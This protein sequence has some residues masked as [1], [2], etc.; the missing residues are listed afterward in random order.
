MWLQV[1][2]CRC[3]FV[4]VAAA[5]YVWLWLCVWVCPFTWW[6][7]LQHQ[8]L[9][10]GPL[11]ID[12]HQYSNKMAVIKWV[13]ETQ[14]K[15]PSKYIPFYAKTGSNASKWQEFLDQAQLWLWSGS[16]WSSISVGEVREVNN[17][18]Y[19]LHIFPG[20]SHPGWVTKEVYDRHSHEL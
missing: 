20:C 18:K 3:G 16:A 10:G 12:H 6:Y 15:S 13:S 14:Y 5:V 19:I 11:T 2:W 9:L 17:H 1:R 4:G 8:A 7:P